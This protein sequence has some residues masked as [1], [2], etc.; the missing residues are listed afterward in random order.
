MN[1]EA[2]INKLKEPS[3][4]A[5]FSALALAFGMTGTEWTD[6]SVGMAAVCGVIAVLFKEKAS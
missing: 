5:G 6:I 3:T 4:W 1:L 2:L